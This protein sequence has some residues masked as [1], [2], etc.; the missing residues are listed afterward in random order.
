MNRRLVFI[1][2]FLRPLVSI[3]LRLKFGYTY[4]GPKTTLPDNYIVLSNHVTDYDPVFVGVAFPRQMYFV[5][6][7]HI[8]RW[9]H[10]FKLLNFA[11][12]PILRHKGSL[13]AST[14]VDILR[15]TRSGSNV[16]MFAEGVRTWDGVT[17]PIL[18]S[19]GKLVKKSGCGLVT[20]RIT[21]GYFVSP[22]W[23][24]SLRRGPVSG[25]VVNVYTKQ[26]LDEM[27]I[28]EVNAAIKA[29][30]YE[31]AYDRQLK[32]PKKYKGKALAA[33]FENLLFVCPQ[34]GK[35]DCISTHGN[36]I[37]CSACGHSFDYDEYGMLRGGRFKTV[38]ELA[39]WQEAQVAGDAVAAQYT[40]SS[41][42][43]LTVV[44]HEESIAAEG[45]VS[46]TADSLTCGSLS[47]PVSSISEMDIHGNHAIVFTSGKDY[48][49]LRPSGNAYKY[50]LL[51]RA[52]KSVKV[53][54][55]S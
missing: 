48:Y 43:L 53:P 50:L 6:S 27:S 36:T 15:K 1:Y 41:G 14:V 12:A 51:Y 22:H 17:C 34:C 11:L 47:I 45:P 2:T 16:A 55:K 42:T 20:F 26:Q 33:G 35:P 28:A 29:D 39:L 7:E 32:S 30:L 18:P 4:T 23:S 10:G 44:S 31:D 24:T 13:A 52:L 21:G 3:F 5:A 19:T 37:T 54:A 8:S 40:S 38:R 25:S 49:E 46:M 9:K